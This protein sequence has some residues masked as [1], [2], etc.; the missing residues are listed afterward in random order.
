MYFGK[1]TDHQ[2]LYRDMRL[3]LMGQR[4]DVLDGCQDPYIR[5]A[6]FKERSGAM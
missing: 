5:R 1:A 3:G 4:N 6:F 2:A